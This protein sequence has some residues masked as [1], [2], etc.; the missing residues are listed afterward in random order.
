MDAC[1]CYVGEICGGFTHGPHTAR[2]AGIL[3][4]TCE[5]EVV[6]GQSCVDYGG[7]SEDGDCFRGR[8]HATCWQLTRLF[9]DRVCGTE[10]FGGM[11]LEEAAEHAMA[12]GHDPFWKSWLLLYETTWALSAP[13]EEPSKED[14]PDA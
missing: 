13:T 2:K 3:C 12:E 10:W 4:D 11:D 5:Q 7:I 6:P 8:Q 1:S 9:K 14:S